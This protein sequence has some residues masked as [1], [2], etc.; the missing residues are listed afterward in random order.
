M[1]DPIS[2]SGGIRNIGLQDGQ[3]NKTRSS[4][5]EAGKSDAL[6]P[7]DEVSISAEALD[8]ASAEKAAKEAKVALEVSQDTSLGLDPNFDITV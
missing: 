1:T 6:T 5:D 2:S 3:G 4:K 8:Q 7:K